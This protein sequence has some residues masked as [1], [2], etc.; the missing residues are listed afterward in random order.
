MFADNVNGELLLFLPLL[1]LNSFDQGVDICFAVRNNQMHLGLIK[2]SN[3]CMEVVQYSSPSN[4]PVCVLGSLCLTCYLRSDGSFTF[5]ELHRVAKFA[6]KSLDR[7]IDL[8]DY[9]VSDAAT[10]AYRTRPVSVGVQ[11]LADVFA[12]LEIPFTS[13]VARSISRGI[14]EA[15]Y[16]AALECSCELAEDLGAYDCWQHSP[17]QQGVL[18]LNM[19]DADTSNQYDFDT[20]RDHMCATGLQNSVLTAQMP[21]ASTSPLFSTSEGVNPYTRYA[22]QST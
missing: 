4:T 6:V 15:V 18:Q 10:S 5:P 12:N 17:A 19:W 9:P 7:L 13:P 1:H 8:S 11:G 14:A 16:H 22:S 20:L 21:T 2:S 3:L